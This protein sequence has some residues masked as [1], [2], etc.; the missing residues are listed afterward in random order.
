[1]RY[2]IGIIHKDD[3]SDFGIS[4]P[5]FLGCVSAGS[6]LDEALAMGREALAGHV[7]L[8]VDEGEAI[9]EPS[10][11]EAVMEDPDYRDGT[12]VL[13]PAPEI[14]AR[15]VRVNITLPA[16]ALRDIDRFAEAH[17]LTR[18]GFLASAARKALEAAP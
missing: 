14:S 8:M 15:I 3:D 17:G 18:S 5:D 4:F 7:E 10:S 6:T 9:P 12:P 11:L 16:D 1:M 13:V 2:Y